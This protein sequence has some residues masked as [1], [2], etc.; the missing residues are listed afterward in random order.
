MFFQIENVTLSTI[1]SDVN[2]GEGPKVDL[3]SNSQ[4]EPRKSTIGARKTPAKKTVRTFVVFCKIICLK[5]YDCAVQLFCNV[6]L[7]VIVFSY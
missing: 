3:T 1:A 7:H 6:I 2:P 5:L 4:S